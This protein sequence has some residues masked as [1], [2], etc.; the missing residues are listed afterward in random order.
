LGEACRGVETA[1]TRQPHQIVTLKRCRWERPATPDRFHARR[2]AP[3]LH[4]ERQGFENAGNLRI[5][6]L[7]FVLC[8]CSANFGRFLVV[9]YRIAQIS[10][11]NL[12]CANPPRTRRSKPPKLSFRV[13]TLIAGRLRNNQTQSIVDNRFVNR[14]VN[15]SRENETKKFGLRRPVVI[16]N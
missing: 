3:P 1:C 15:D 13:C 9:Y 12:A 7:V 2:C 4:P 16:W 10:G 11:L 6:A 14:F 5:P 8:R